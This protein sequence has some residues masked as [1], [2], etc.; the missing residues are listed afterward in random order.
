M[1]S[2]EGS[3]SSSNIL[4]NRRY[5][6]HA[7]MRDSIISTGVDSDDVMA[8]AERLSKSCSVENALCMNFINNHKRY[9]H[10]YL[11]EDVD[12]SKQI[13]LN[14]SSLNST[15]R[16]KIRQPFSPLIID[17]NT[18][19][20]NIPVES[21]LATNNKNVL[22]R[23]KLCNI[24]VVEPPTLCNS[25][26]LQQ[27]Q[28]YGRKLVI[29]KSIDHLNNNK[30][31]LG[32]IEELT[33]LR[34]IKPA[35][36]PSNDLPRCPLRHLPDIKATLVKKP[37]MLKRH[38]FPPTNTTTRCKSALPEKCNTNSILP[39]VEVAP[40]SLKP[41]TRYRDESPLFADTYSDDDF[42]SVSDDEEEEEEICVRKQMK[43]NEKIH[44]FLDCI[45]NSGE[46]C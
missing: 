44:R 38:S 12:L 42:D 19:T 2:V 26:V 34:P 39:L 20:R 21:T 16:I 31:D 28:R 11:E 18:T 25:P 9:N 5:G 36:R 35:T 45:G 24:N 1:I 23:D 37:P 30:S 6:N 46:Y 15:K 7:T 8:A 13:N 3:L 33:V 10:G 4:Y 17:R 14:L 27:H 40:S 43:N 41:N 32:T 29:S 22:N